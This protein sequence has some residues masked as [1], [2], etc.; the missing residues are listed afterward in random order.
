MLGGSILDIFGLDAAEKLAY[1]WLDRDLKGSQ[2]GI[3][4]DLSRR[5]GSV[6]AESLSNG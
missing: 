3:A 1:E 4:V 2:M 5:S 6:C